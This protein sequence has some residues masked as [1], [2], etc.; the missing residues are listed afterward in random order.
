MDEIDEYLIKINNILDINYL[1]ILDNNMSKF[2][3]FKKILY[4]ILN[5]Y[6]DYTKE[7]LHK[8][9]LYLCMIILALD[10]T[11]EYN[12]IK[13]HSIFKIIY[14]CITKL[15]IKYD[16]ELDLD[17]ISIYETF[18]FE[19]NSKNSKIDILNNLLGNYYTAELING[20]YR[21][22]IYQYF[23]TQDGYQEILLSP[24]FK[25][26]NLYDY[27]AKLIT[28]NKELLIQISTEIIL[29]E[30][31]ET[32]FNDYPYYLIQ[33]EYLHNKI[34]SKLLNAFI[35]AEYYQIQYI[36]KISDTKLR[37]DSDLFIYTYRIL[38][39]YLHETIYDDNYYFN[40]KNKFIELLN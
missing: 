16:L 39:K 26:L 12:I 7:T 34:D 8:T 37:G 4:R 23:N 24:K 10:E 29:A 3:L 18:D 15:N 14:L 35:L 11:I 32:N 1:Y 9:K 38:L 13:E 36:L 33:S 5:S 22:I 19:I 30:I 40:I 2:V 27:D 20:S 21:N 6:N 17:N 28:I 25:Q 31:I